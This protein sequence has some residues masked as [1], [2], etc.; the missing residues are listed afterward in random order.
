MRTPRQSPN[1][2]V[3]LG[4]AIAFAAYGALT[5]TVLGPRPV[6]AVLWFAAAVVLVVAARLGIRAARRANI[7]AGTVWLLLGYAGLFVIG[8]PANVLGMIAPDLV[9]LF[10]AATLQLAA[11]LGARRDVAALAA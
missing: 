2:L 11:G 4:L 1:R 10:G 6:I 8:S 9:A 5:L 7:V 3:A